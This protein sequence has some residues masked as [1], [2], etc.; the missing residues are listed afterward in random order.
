M[1]RKTRDGDSVEEDREEKV[2]CQLR[3]VD[4]TDQTEQEQPGHFSI[5]GLRFGT[6]S[7]AG[8]KSS[9]EDRHVS[10]ADFFPGPVFGIFDGHGGTFSASFL[11]R[12]LVK[13]AASVI[14]QV[15][16]EKALAGL[17]CSRD[18][19]MQE[20]AR[21]A[22]LRKQATMLRQQLEEVEA[23][24]SVT[25]VPAS[26][27]SANDL[28]VLADQ[29]SKAIA[30][31]DSEAKQIDVEE[32]ERQRNR[33]QWCSRL[34]SCFLKS[35]RESFRRVDLQI[36]QKNPSQDGS[37]A[38]LVWFLADSV[39]FDDDETAATNGENNTL[40]FYAINVGDCRAVMCRGGRGVPLT[41]DHK[42]DRPDERQRI[43]KA[44]GYVGK[45]AGIPRVYSAAGAGLSMRREVSTHLAVSR[46]FGD[47]SLK[48]P[49]PL[50]SCEPEVARFQVLTDDLFLILACDGIWD[51][52]SEQDAVDIAL[53]HFHDAKAAAGAIVKAAYKK[54]SLDNLTATVVQFAWKT[55]DQLQQGIDTSKKVTKARTRKSEQN[56][57][58]ADSLVG[59]G[60]DDEIDMFNL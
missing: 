20:K 44:G 54:G 53:P 23:M 31:M 39:N 15:I 12:Q 19:S 29:L 17:R 11:S 3:N 40:S 45:I 32:A 47:Q 28:H 52:M 46:A 7:W 43:E 41:S 42:P 21:K 13:T 5:C 56:L 18:R 4:K 49:A 16:G 57:A 22:A 50:V 2:S 8:M 9:N 48:H 25:A 38:L 33:W 35:F 51:V 55:G 60:S 34:H 10:S 27:S 1:K 30:E 36:L 59:N 14:R 24:R 37:T 58:S 6:E 26:E